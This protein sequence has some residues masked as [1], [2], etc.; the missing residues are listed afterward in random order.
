MRVALERSRTRHLSAVIALGITVVACSSV[1]ADSATTTTTVSATSTTAGDRPGTTSPSSANDNWDPELT[2]RLLELEQGADGEW[3]VESAVEAYELL[4]P[5]LAAG[6][7]EYP[8]IDITGL[9]WFLGEHIDDL[10][11]EQRSTFTAQAGPSL[12]TIGHTVAR[13][14]AE[15]EAFQLAA[16]TASSDFASRTGHTLPSEIVVAYSQ[17]GLLPGGLSAGTKTPVDPDWELY[18]G[19]FATDVEFERMREQFDAATADGDAGCLIIIGERFR[20]RSPEPRSASIYHEVVHCHQQAIH[21]GGPAGFFHNPVKWMDEGYASWAGEYLVGGTTISKQFWDIYHDGVGQVGGHH[22]TEG[23]YDAIALFSYLHDNGVDGWAGFVNWFGSVRGDG[24]SDAAKFEALFSPLS[25]EAKAAWAATSLQRPEFSE[26]WTY[27]T[28]PGIG[29]STIARTPRP[30]PVAVG[31]G[32]RFALAPGEQ[33]TYAFEPRLADADALLLE[34][35]LPNGGVIRWPW[36]EDQVSTGALDVAWCLGDECVCDDGRELGPPAPEFT[37]SPFVT[38]AL[39]GGVVTVD[40]VEPEDECEEEEPIVGATGACPV[41]IWAADPQ[42]T[43]DL[44]LTLYREFGI[45]DPTY[46]GGPVTMSFF[47]DGSFRFDYVETTFSE[48]IEGLDARFVLNGGSA[49]TWEADS[50]TLTVQIDSQDIVLELFLDG[51]PA[52]TNSPPGAT[53]G[54]SA[55]YACDGNDTLEIDPAFEQPFW[56]YPRKW[57]RVIP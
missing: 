21:P 41:G 14:E 47:D 29:N 18:R 10:T 9:M 22:T 39:T 4:Q 1:G 43:E 28:G 48:T 37:E 26:I 7:D 49:G 17:L 32:P 2:T 42:A 16:E 53:G 11:D 55:P 3:T 15:R 35:S 54:G 33:G 40:L 23:G 34:V 45:A 12:M 13:V 19:F 57:S 20:N 38:V 44:L 31:S 50:T 51:T 8:P 6:V 56:P 36:G 46:E 27:T 5:I 52:V 30:T 25:G 24:G